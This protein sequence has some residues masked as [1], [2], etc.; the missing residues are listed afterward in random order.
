MPIPHPLMVLYPSLLTT[1]R[2]HPISKFSFRC[3]LDHISNFP[4]LLLA[5]KKPFVVPKTIESK[6]HPPHVQA[7]LRSV[8]SAQQ[9]ADALKSDHISNDVLSLVGKA[10]TY[11]NRLWQF[12]LLIHLRLLKRGMGLL[13]E[14]LMV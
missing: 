10:A 12:L 8:L 5:T 13:P 11:A 3:I 7:R 9:S 4:I 6:T 1:H 14:G 2:L